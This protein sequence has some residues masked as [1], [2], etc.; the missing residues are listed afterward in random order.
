MKSLIHRIVPY[1]A[2]IGRYSVIAASDHVWVTVQT[3][4]WGNST[5]AADSRLLVP[6]GRGN[7]VS[8]LEVLSHFQSAVCCYLSR[9]RTSK[10][11]PLSSLHNGFIC[12]CEHKQLQKSKHLL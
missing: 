1:A 3:L 8:V 4:R 6:W 11:E 9:R 5:E 2:V 7:C 10:A 12:S